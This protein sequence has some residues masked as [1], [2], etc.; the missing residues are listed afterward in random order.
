MPRL[1]TEQ[2]RALYSHVLRRMETT[3]AGQRASIPEY[4]LGPTGRQT[5]ALDLTLAL[6]SAAQVHSPTPEE[7]RTMTENNRTA[8]R[9]GIMLAQDPNSPA[10][11]TR[12][13]Y[14]N[15]PEQIE[16]RDT[17]WRLLSQ[18]V[19]PSVDPGLAPLATRLGFSEQMSTLAGTGTQLLRD[20]RNH[21]GQ[22]RTALSEA[23]QR[24]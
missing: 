24:G 7:K 17:L 22:A 12:I 20:Y 18:R 10:E 9:L 16:A 2:S 5:S 4:N 14:V 8:H 11:T 6:L 3:T 21:L 13:S 15:R 19:D 1:E 23:Q